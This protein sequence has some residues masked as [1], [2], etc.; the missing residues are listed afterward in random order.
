M[1]RMFRQAL[2]ILAAK[3]RLAGWMALVALSGSASAVELQFTQV[4]DHSS[5][6]DI[7]HAG[8]GSG[9]L[10]IV[11]QSGSVHI[12]D[13]D[14]ELDT[15]FLDIGGRVFD[16]GN[17]QGLLSLAF[18]PDYAQSGFFYVWYTGSGGATRLSRFHVDDADPNLADTGSEQILLELDQPFGNHNGGRLQFGPDGYLYLGIGDGG[19]GGDPM[20]HGQNPDTLLGSLIRIDVDP[21]HG[22]YAV[23]EDNPFVGGPGAD[24]I[25]AIGLRNPWR[26]SFDRQTGQLYIA[27]VGQNS[28]EEINVQPATGGGGRNY[29]WNTMEGSACFT[30]PDCATAGLTTP[31][32]EYP[33]ALGC[34][35]TGGEVYRGNAYPDLQGVYLYGDFCSGTIWGLEQVGGDWEDRVL[36]STDFRISTFGQ[37][38]DGS[39]Y[40]AH[41]GGGVFRISDG[42][43]VAEPP[44]SINA[45]LNDAWHDPDTAGQGMFITVFPPLELVFVAWFTFEAERPAD[46]VGAAFGDPGHRWL[47]AIGRYSGNSA[48][49]AV[50][51]TA[52]GILNAETPAPVQTEYGELEL[53][54]TGCDTASVTWHLPQAGL[55]G[56]ATLQRV[57]PDNVVLCEALSAD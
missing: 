25:W 14:S 56:Q 50:E 41:R 29:G 35:V 24:E 6:T 49:L 15:P 27:D 17:E 37:G 44:F 53:R 18:P 42:Q 31:V 51:L 5:V 30:D 2:P 34:S 57:N 9:R 43:P 4:S 23:P 33:H 36:A 20:G 40:L 45:G 52:G 54:F 47:T 7:R 46:G 8:D 1:T 22:G 11:Q 28:V 21:A 16:Q 12:L 48:E 38:E 13:G 32:A 39:L 26:I 3:V 10:F 19:S 55:D